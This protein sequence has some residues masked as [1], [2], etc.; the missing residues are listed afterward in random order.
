MNGRDSCQ[1]CRTSGAR[2]SRRPVVW[3]VRVASCLLLAC[4]FISQAL[5]DYTIDTV[6][7]AASGRYDELEGLLEPM[8]GKAPLGTRDLHALCFA[9]SKTK[10]Y[11][12][13]LPCL[14]RLEANVRKGDRRT[15]LFGLDDATPAIHAMRAEAY[16]E[17][18]QYP[19]AAKEALR[20]LQWLE[21]DRSDD[22][23][24]IV[25]SLAAMSLGSTL[26]GN[27]A[28]GE[29]YAERIAAVSTFMPQHRDYSTAKSMALARAYTALGKFDKALHALETDSSFKLVAFFDNLVSGA[30]FKGTNNWAWVDLPRAYMIHKAQKEVGRSADAKAGFDK[31]L[32]LPQIRAN[33]EIYWLILYDRGLL[34]HAEEHLDEA[35]DLYRKAVDVIEQQRSTINTETNKIG[36]V[37]DKQAVYGNLIRAAFA[38][39]KYELAY[40]YAERAR[41]RALVDLL[42]ERQD[43]ALPESAGK[44]VDVKSLLDA[45]RD[46]GQAATVQRPVDNSQAGESRQRNLMVKTGA[47]LQ[48]VAPELA[49]LVSVQAPSTKEILAQ[50]PAGE[51]IVEYYFTERELLAFILKDGRLR[52]ARL[53][54][55]GLDGKVRDFRRQ[56]ESQGAGVEDLARSLYIQL[57]RPIETDIGTDQVLFIPH[58]I[59]HYLP[60]SA[61]HDGK[62]YLVAS[63]SVRYLPSASVLRF[64]RPVR[65]KGIQNILVL[66]N[67]DL[68][69]ARYDLPNAESEAR[70]IAKLVPGSELLVRAKASEL[71]FKRFAANFE[72]LHI[73]SHGEFNSDEPLKSRLMLARDGA[74]DGF[75]TA[76]EIYDLKL[77]ANLVTLSACET[78][79]GHVASGDDIIGL[80][81]ALLYAGTSNV[82]ASLW[83]VDD[84]AT[85]EL[86]T[87]FYQNL[88]QGDAVRHALRRAQSAVKARMPHPFFWAPFFVVGQG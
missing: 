19:Q 80:T 37:G 9:Y 78:G 88:M 47:A 5:A 82:V 69:E 75:L 2:G 70:G 15:R 73:A 64:L 31:L 34:A 45:Y 55:N 46:A 41:A 42:A 30:L 79:L 54:A 36:F 6:D 86:M 59:L 28:D 58:G 18:G 65:S 85:S 39:N 77:N 83:Q 50:I 72:F 14:D 21:K 62:D 25:Q 53:D 8:A 81:R 43:F 23:D 3:R 49:S 74:D 52:V 17:L 24:M 60:F 61:L 13:L 20:G 57:V 16:I 67:P 56:I 22:K 27:R 12:L 35:I 44:D 84:L 4:S 38:A 51:A 71:A 26:S 33:G 32:S 40:E 7:F 29:K 66:G 11:N 76:G 48:S 63:R 68:G 87:A 1:A 10:R